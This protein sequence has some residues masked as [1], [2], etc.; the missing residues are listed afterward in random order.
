MKNLQFLFETSLQPAQF[1]DG[2]II[3]RHK[4][5]LDSY[6]QNSDRL[7]QADSASAWFSSDRTKFFGPSRILSRIIYN[8]LD[9][10]DRDLTIIDFGCGDGLFI[11]LL[12]SMGFLRVYGV[13]SNPLNSF[14]KFFKIEDCINQKIQKCDIFI[15]LNVAH[16]LPYKDFLS[17]AKS[18][19]P[20]LIFFDRE[21]S[22]NLYSNQYYNNPEFFNIWYRKCFENTGINTELLFKVCDS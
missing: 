6:Y 8:Y 7:I 19:N 22:R 16:E 12:K 15:G 1:F 9:M 2:K 18:Y 4:K 13:D 3:K 5:L 21:F 10:L 11:K 20:S 17:L 14:Y